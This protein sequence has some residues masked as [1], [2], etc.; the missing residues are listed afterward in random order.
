M[1]LEIISTV[2]EEVGVKRFAH[3]TVSNV[4]LSIVSVQ[5]RG[6]GQRECVHANAL[7][8][9]GS[10]RSFCAVELS[11]RLGLD[12]TFTTLSLE[13]INST[14]EVIEGKLDLEVIGS[15]GKRRNRN[16]IPLNSVFS[17]K[18]FPKLGS[19]I[20]VNTSKWKHVRNRLRMMKA[21]V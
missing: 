1:T 8:D 7:L 11:L 17:M 12:S 19:I 15:C 9:S 14:E 10:K 4:A 18:C 2:S 5:V 3:K 6:I 13:T 21:S 20:N 16:V